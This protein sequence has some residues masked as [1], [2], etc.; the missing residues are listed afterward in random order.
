VVALNLD[1]FRCI[2]LHRSS[3]KQKKIRVNL[4]VHP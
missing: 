3:N 2:M 4:R 1:N